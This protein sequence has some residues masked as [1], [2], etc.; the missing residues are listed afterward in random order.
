MPVN[1]L[2]GGSHAAAEP[3]NETAGGND[4]NSNGTNT[5][6]SRIH[7]IQKKIGS[8]FGK[9][10]YRYVQLKSSVNFN[11]YIFITGYK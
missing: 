1:L 6:H 2:P 3:V 8:T 5:R 9:R 11:N 4:E 10:Q 7:G